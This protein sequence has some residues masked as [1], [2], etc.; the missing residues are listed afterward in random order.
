IGS[1]EVQA[2][3]APGLPAQG[4]PPFDPLSARLA[5]A[6][7]PRAEMLP[8]TRTPADRSEKAVPQA[9]GMDLAGTV[10][11]VTPAP[12]LAG[13][14]AYTAAVGWGETVPDVLALGLMQPTEWVF[15]PY[16]DGV[17]APAGTRTWG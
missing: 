9:M 1:F 3:S 4:Q 12:A 5:G 6:D 11:S 13:H 17:G 2:S 15:H 14:A 16:E 7:R 8:V 10:S